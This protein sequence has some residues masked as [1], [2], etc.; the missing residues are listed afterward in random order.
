MVEIQH[1]PI[2]F[3]IENSN[4]PQMPLRFLCTPMD[5]F[6]VFWPI[7]IASTS[8][9]R[10]QA[11]AVWQNPQTQRRES[12]LCINFTFLLCHKHTNIVLKPTSSFG[13]QYCRI[14][15]KNSGHGLSKTRTL[16]ILGERGSH[17]YIYYPR[18]SFCVHGEKWRNGILLM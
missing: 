18:S 17:Y 12:F 5:I 3:S 1:L 7:V 6:C 14:S 10:D 8:R 13:P 9:T 2:S 11:N 4:P 16:G 15:F